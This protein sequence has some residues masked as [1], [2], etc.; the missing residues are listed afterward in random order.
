MITKNSKGSNGMKRYLFILLATVSILFLGGC[1]NDK[2]V[3]KR[4]KIIPIDTNIAYADIAEPN[5]ET[6]VL[7]YADPRTEEHGLNRVLRVNYRN[8]SFDSVTCV[9]INPHS[10]DRA[11]PTQKFYVRTQ[12]S[13]SFDVVN[14]ANQTVITVDM[15]HTHAVDGTELYHKPRAIGAYNRKYNIQLLSVK[16]RPAV[17]VID[18]AQD[19]ILTVLGDN[20]DYNQ[21]DIT[22]NGGSGSATG[23]A[24]WFDED[25]LGVL[26]RVD[27]KV[28]VYRVEKDNVNNTL[29]F[30]LIQQF[31]TRYP[32]HTIERVEHAR[33]LKDTY[34]F[35]S[36]VEGD[37]SAGRPPEIV[38]IRFDP[39]SGT[40]AETGK[41]IELSDCIQNVTVQMDDGKNKK[42]KPTTHHL[43]ISPNGKYL[44][45]PV[46]DKKVYI[47]DRKTFSLVRLI[48]KDINNNDDD[49]LLGAAHVNFSKQ[50]NVAI[51]TSHFSRYITVIDMKTFETKHVPIT[52][53]AAKEQVLADDE[54][55]HLLQ[56]HFSY[57]DPNGQYFYTFA[58]QGTH[59]THN[60]DNERGIFIKLDLEVLK[61]LSQQDIDA[62]DL[63]NIDDHYNDLGIEILKTG[64]APEQA[65]S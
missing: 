65:H 8:M 28:W 32:V 13:L 61:N 12:N 42:I 10:I 63:H 44:V 48:E 43:G 60:D 34:L 38:E 16:N 21:E 40:L 27:S 17:D 54:N 53:Y 6:N 33:K 59:N 56:P 25:H 5:G 49:R 39:F 19:K 62:V 23:H 30:T 58:T 18:V 52:N 29:D 57:V 15:N 7:Y 11:G 24:M 26:D 20:T 9:G 2:F 35:Y 41:S 1:N 36:T 47:I 51:V 3:D 22:S 55:I 37:V 45:V 50:Y 46:F 31:S 14:F 64:G 4:D